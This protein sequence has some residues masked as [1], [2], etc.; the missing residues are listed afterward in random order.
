VLRRL[1]LRAPKWIA[2]FRS[3]AR[4]VLDVIHV[5]SSFVLRRREGETVGLCQSGPALA[6]PRG[7]ALPTWP[8]QQ[9]LEEERQQIARLE[10]EKAL[11]S[12][13]TLGVFNF[14]RCSKKHSCVLE[15]DITKSTPFFG[16]AI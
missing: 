3:P 5:S 14:R 16:L 15:M 11:G 1:R 6:K 7:W 2:A 12:L 8:Q 10:G 4:C 13:K 9:A